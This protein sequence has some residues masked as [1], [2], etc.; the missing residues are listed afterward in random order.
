MLCG[1]L[2]A[3]GS[4]TKSSASAFLVANCTAQCVAVQSLSERG[5]RLV[6]ARTARRSSPC[7]FQH[8]A[9]KAGKHGHTLS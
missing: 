2:Q 8:K 4:N 9:N 6:C 3:N 5:P 1:P 7:R